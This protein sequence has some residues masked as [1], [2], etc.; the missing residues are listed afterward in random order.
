M[1]MVLMGK[2]EGKKPF[3]RRRHGW[4]DRIEMDLKEIGR[5]GLYW[6]DLARGRDKFCAFVNT[7]VKLVGN[8]VTS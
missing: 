7:I 8:F 2:P 1:Y 4:A 3:A 6:I 5:G